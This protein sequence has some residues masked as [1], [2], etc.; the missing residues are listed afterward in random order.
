MSLIE[1]DLRFLGTD[2]PELLPLC[3]QIASIGSSESVFGSLY[4][5]EGA[6]LGGQYI[7][8]H[9]QQVLNVT[10]E[11]GGH[12]FRGYGQRTG[13][14]WQTFRSTLDSFAL[15]QQTQDRVLFTALETFKTLRTW[16]LRGSTDG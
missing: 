5:V 3:A 13:E 8:R 10:P 4:V 16:F 11:S 9:V 7:S 6:T 1:Q 12:F 14:M 15:T 2:R